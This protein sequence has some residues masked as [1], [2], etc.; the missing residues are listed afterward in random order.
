MHGW[1]LLRTAT[2]ASALL[3]MIAAVDLATGPELSFSLFYLG[4][5]ALFAWRT[6]LLGGIGASVVGATAWYAVGIVG[7]ETY[8][9]ALIPLWNALVRF[10]FFVVVSILLTKLK[11]TMEHERA[12]AGTDP[13]TGLLNRRALLERAST[14]IERARRS[15]RPIAFAFIDLDDFKAVNDRFGHAAGDEKL[16]QVATALGLVVRAVDI[17]ARIG[18]DEFAVVLPDTDGD[19][20]RAVVDRLSSAFHAA[21]I[22]FSL[23]AAVFVS[24]PQTVDS[25]LSRVDSLMYAVKADRSKHTEVCIIGP[26][27]EPSRA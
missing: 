9:H 6:G 16:L 3:A 14:E 23:G 26:V 21:D 5:I 17:T 7:G 19:A 4:P 22:A 13:L 12:L 15:G 8:S 11:R 1:T 25:A 18:G 24:P 10:G 27:Q 2:A 20:A